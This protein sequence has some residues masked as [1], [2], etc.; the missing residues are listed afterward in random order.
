M[1]MSNVVVQAEGLVKYFDGRAVL[2]GIDL[3]VPRGCIY[4]LLGRNGAGKTTL[5]RIL[6]GPKISVCCSCYF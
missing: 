2:K 4:G 1:T 3:A 6:P 5:I